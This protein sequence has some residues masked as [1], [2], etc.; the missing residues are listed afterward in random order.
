MRT[1][2]VLIKELP[3]TMRRPRSALGRRSP[4]W[5]LYFG[6]S[7]GV[8]AIGVRRVRRAA[9]GEAADA[10]ADRQ[11]TF[12]PCSARA[13]GDQGCDRTGRCTGRQ[14]GA[15]S[16]ESLRRTGG[17]LPLPRRRPRSVRLESAL[18]EGARVEGARVESVSHTLALVTGRQN[19][20][21]GR[22]SEAAR[23]RG[24]ATHRQRARMKTATKRGAPEERPPSKPCRSP[25][26]R[27]QC[28]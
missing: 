26:R 17:R 14:A 2:A 16:G 21:A 13:D 11:R 27:R 4:D 15:C 19:G 23:R 6:L 3:S 20:T 22:H 25:R 10:A 28:R 9:R 12:R 8:A 1:C 7:A 18:L 24:A 5:A